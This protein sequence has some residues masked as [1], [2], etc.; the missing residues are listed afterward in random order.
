MKCILNV[1]FISLLMN[2]KDTYTDIYVYRNTLLPN[3]AYKMLWKKN[4]WCVQV[5]F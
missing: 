2:R 3:K 4:C 1:W 5:H